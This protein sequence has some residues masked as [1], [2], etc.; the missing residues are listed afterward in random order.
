MNVNIE[1]GRILLLIMRAA[2]FSM[3]KKLKKLSQH[4]SGLANLAV[5]G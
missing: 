2:I 5:P 1:R 3:P 4:N